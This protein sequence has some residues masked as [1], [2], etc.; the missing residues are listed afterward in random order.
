MAM[1]GTF[2]AVA[3]HHGSMTMRRTSIA[4]AAVHHGHGGHGTWLWGEPPSRSQRST[5]DMADMK[6]GYGGT[7]IAVAAI[8]HEHEEHYKHV[9]NNLYR[10]MT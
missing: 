6:H 4:V 7:L 3:V 10:I 2:I 9:N 8:Y 1:E 5:M